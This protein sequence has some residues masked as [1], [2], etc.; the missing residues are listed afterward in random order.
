[1]WLI[2]NSKTYT[3]KTLNIAGK[4]IA[5]KLKV[6]VSGGKAFCKLI[7]GGASFGKDGITAEYSKSFGT[8]K[9]TI[10]SFAFPAM[11]AV[12]VGLTGKASLK[13]T[14]KFASKAKTKLNFSL[15]GSVTADAYVKAGWDAAVSITAGASGTLVSATISAGVS[16][17]GISYSKSLSGGKIVAYVKGKALKTFE[18]FKY[19]RTIFKGW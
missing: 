10:F 19:E 1:M 2:S 12:S 11:P 5:I 17:S 13:L 16:K 18:L 6:G 8:G 3:L 15:T 4:S 9:I 7:I 14:I